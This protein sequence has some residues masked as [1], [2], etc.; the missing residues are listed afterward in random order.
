ML[1]GVPAYGK[2]PDSG[3]NVSWS[4]MVG[5]KLMHTAC[6]L[7]EMYK[8]NSVKNTDCLW[9]KVACFMVHLQA[10]SDLPCTAPESDCCT[11]AG[12]CVLACV[13]LSHRATAGA[14]VT[15]ETAAT[16]VTMVT[17]ATMAT[18]GTMA[19]MVTTAAMVAKAE[20]AVTT[21]M[22]AM[23]GTVVTVAAKVA[24]T[25]AMAASMAT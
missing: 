12:A 23:S 17:T 15:T 1:Y 6:K 21:T 18:M 22:E 25:A 13:L 8:T 4:R 11:S 10:A 9:E 5:F 2:K 7:E 3:N 20:R 24:T 16:M 14:T 19:T